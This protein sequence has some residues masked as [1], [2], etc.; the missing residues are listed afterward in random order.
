MIK[1]STI[2]NLLNL[3][4]KHHENVTWE[5][6]CAYADGMGTTFNQIKIFAHPGNRTIGIFTYRVETGKI[7]FCMYKKLKEPVSENIVDV[8]LDMINYSKEQKII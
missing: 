6:E 7:S 3:F 8:L 5:L 1:K 4:S 2:S